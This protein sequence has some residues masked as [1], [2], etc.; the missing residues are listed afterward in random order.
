MVL[1]LLN[2]MTLVKMVL[3]RLL[4]FFALRVHDPRF[5]KDQPRLLL[6]DV[7]VPLSTQIQPPDLIFLIGFE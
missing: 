1:L 4:L 6:L 5:L 7:P 2:E 3:H